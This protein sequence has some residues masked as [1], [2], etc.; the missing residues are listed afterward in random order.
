MSDNNKTLDGNGNVVVESQPEKKATPKKKPVGR[1]EIVFNEDSCE[2]KKGD[3]RKFDPV[4]ALNLVTVERVASYTDKDM[5]ETAKAEIKRLDDAKKKRTARMKAEIKE[6]A[7]RLEKRLKY[8]KKDALEVATQ[9]I[10]NR[11]K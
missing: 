8:P 6:E 4:V 9:T 2:F 5:Q 1:V 11:Y 7:N 3:L 10:K